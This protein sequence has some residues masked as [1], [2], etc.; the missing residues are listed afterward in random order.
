M[1]TLL[2]LFKSTVN[3]ELPNSAT[4]LSCNNKLSFM[5]NYYLN[6]LLHIVI[7]SKSRNI[8][9]YLTI[10]FSRMTV[11]RESYM[12]ENSLR[13]GVL[14]LESPNHKGFTCEYWTDS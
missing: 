1:F 2:P 8:H 7:Y 12:C 9:E 13:H 14:A 11:I 5:I 6:Q 4:S 3:N 10:A